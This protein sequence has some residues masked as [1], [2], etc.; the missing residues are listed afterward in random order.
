MVV[1]L[2]YFLVWDAYRED[3]A[4]ARPS[5]LEFSPA[6]VWRGVTNNLD[7]SDSFVRLVLADP[8][9]EYGTTYLAPGTKPIPRS[10]WEGKPLGGNSR[11]TETI[12]PGVL[13]VG[14]SRAASAV[15]EGYLNFGPVGPALVYV[16]LAMACAALVRWRLARTTRPDATLWYAIWFLG[17][18]TFVRTDAQIA[19]TF[20]GY[21]LPPLF[22]LALLTGW[23]LPSRGRLQPSPRSNQGPRGATRRLLRRGRRSAA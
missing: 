7:Y 22:V 5:G 11:L 19:T 1:A 16:L 18:I 15:T 3:K 14:F 9:L 21:Y 17:V 8:P 10:V 23:R 6:G 20:L 4:G 13:A 2:A 12:L